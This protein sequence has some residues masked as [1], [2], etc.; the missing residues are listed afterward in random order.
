MHQITIS[1]QFQEFCKLMAN[2]TG[3]EKVMYLKVFVDS[4]EDLKKIY[5]EVANRHNKRI[6][7]EPCFCDAGFD[8]LIP[9]PI[10]EADVPFGGTRCVSSNINFIDFKIRCSASMHNV[11]DLNKYWFTGFFLHPKSSNARTTLRMANSTGIIDSGYRGRIIGMFDAVNYVCRSNN[12]D[13]EYD[14]LIET[15]SRIVQVCAPNLVPIFVEIV[16]DLKDL[17][18]LDTLRG[19]K[20]FGFEMAST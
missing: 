8:I 11:Q 13:S 9:P 16:N 4:D 3:Y 10:S 1:D 18:V 7:S 6:Q 2:E 15:H 12:A 20:A 17:G 5:V 14:C 19:T